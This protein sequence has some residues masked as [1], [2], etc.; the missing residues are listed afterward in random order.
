MFPPFCLTWGQTMVEVSKI[1]ATSFKRSHAHTTALSAPDPAASHC[2][3]TPLTDPPVPES[4]SSSQGISLKGWA[5]SAD[6]DVASDSQ[7]GPSCLFQASCLLLYF[8]KS[9]R[10]EV[11]YFKFSQARFIVSRNHCC[12]SNRVPAS[13]I[14]SESALLSII[15]F[16][17]CV[18]YLWLHCNSCYIPQFISY[19]SKS[20]LPLAS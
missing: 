7:Y 6:D 12:P 9:I 19:L 15:Y 1:L 17:L 18:L 8:D 2:W 14:L 10:S 16:F 13:G 20:C 11:W 4:S 3:P 5:M